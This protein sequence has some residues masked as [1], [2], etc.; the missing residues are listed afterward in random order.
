M[1]EDREKIN[2]VLFE[3]LADDD[4]CR[5]FGFNSA[6][7]LDEIA[8][9]VCLYDTVIS[10]CHSPVKLLHTCLKAGEIAQFLV[11][12]C[13][14]HINQSEE[15]SDFDPMH[16]F[17]NRQA[18][19]P[20]PIPDLDKAA[21]EI[22]V[23]AFAGALRALDLTEKVINGLNT[24]QYEVFELFVTI[25]PS[26]GR[27]PGIHSSSWQNFGFCYCKSFQQRKELADIYLKLALSNT[28]FDDIV[29]AYET[30]T[31]ADLVTANGIDFSSLTHHG[32]RFE[33]PPPCQN[34]AFRLM[35]GV[36]HALSGRFCE[37]F[38]RREDRSHY[39]A[40]ET[41]F[42]LECDVGYGFHLS[43]TWERW[44]LLNFYKY[45]FKL[46]VFDPLK[47]A[48][49]KKDQQRGSL[50]R[51]LNALVPNMRQRIF[52]KNLVGSVLFPNLDGRITATATDGEEISYLPCVFPDHDV[53][54]PPGIQWRR[55]AV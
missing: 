35:V 5:M 52:D 24:A 31:M 39:Q 2:D 53:I 34:S 4:L 36:E 29:S 46:P 38:R 15:R 42:D 17:L 41:H 3:L 11:L 28:T 19:Y 14:L 27:L 33:K 6:S 54:G 51:Y 7:T 8:Q 37:C 45:I 30:S 49:A 26:V 12:F 21:Y 32:I 40:H 23:T 25:Q 43:H 10:W 48:E 13:Q 47:L 55:W 18:A 22:S 20:F 16:W 1:S 44:Q 9:L 50:E